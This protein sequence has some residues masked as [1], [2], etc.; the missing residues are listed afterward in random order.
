MR[1]KLAALLLCLLL[2]FQ[3]SAVP[4]E[5]AGTV[6]FTAVNKN[7]LSLSDATMPFWSGGYLYVPST[8]FTGVGRDLGVSYYPNIAKQ[9]VLLYVD[10]TIYSS[11][12]FDLNKDYAIDNEGNMYFQKPIQRGGVIFLP[13]SLI[14]RCFGLLYST[15]EVDRGYLVWVRNPD[16]DMEERYFADAARSR[17]DYEYSQYLRNQGTAAEETV[18]EQSEPSVVTG[19]RIYL[20][21]EA[22]ESAAVSSLLD[23]LDRYDAQAAFYCT[24]GFLEEAGDLLRRMSAAGQAIGLIADAADDRPVTE[25]LEAGNRLLSQAASVKTRLAWIRNA[26]AEAVAEAEAA[27]FCCLTPDLDRSAYPLSSTGAADTLFQRVTSRSGAVTV[28]LGDGA[29]AAGLGSFLSAAEAADDRCLAMTETV[30]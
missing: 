23:T 19:Q 22:A 28:W 9:T 13:I 29:N 5:A 27:G 6:Y 11:L 10:D 3:M 12:V 15:V 14:A 8:I 2:V 17:M 25:Q 18:P 7:V 20:S 4:S 30:S 26:T 16:M 21:M 1:R 24:A